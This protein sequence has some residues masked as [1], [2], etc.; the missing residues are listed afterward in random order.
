MC[1]SLAWSLD[2]AILVLG[3]P[4]TTDF[5]FWAALGGVAFGA[6]GPTVGWGRWTTHLIGAVFAALLTTLLVGWVLEPEGASP[7]VL[8]GA[9]ADSAVIAWTDLVVERRP[10]DVPVRA[11]PARAWPH[12]VGFVAVRELCRVRSSPA[13]QCGGRHRAV[14]ARQHVADDTPP[15]ALTSSCTRSRRS[16]CSCASTPSTSSPIGCAAGSATHP[17]SPG[18]ISAAVRSSSRWRSWDRFC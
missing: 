6:L 18:S 8:F 16:S 15:D 10:V 1:L 2:D 3:D 5:L 12:R 9:T 13:A 11:P 4:D 14:A 17:R 7:G